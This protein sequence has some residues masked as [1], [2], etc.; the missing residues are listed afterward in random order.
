MLR[1]DRQTDLCLKCPQHI[2][3]LGLRETQKKLRRLVAVLCVKPD[4][5]TRCEADALLH[6]LELEERSW[7]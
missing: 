1:L 7:R 6:R 2:E 5:N 3:L 4:F